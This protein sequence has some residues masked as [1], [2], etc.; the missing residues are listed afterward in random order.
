MTLGSSSSERAIATVWR[1][2]PDSEA[3]T[4][5][6]LGMRADNS[7]SSVQARISIAT[8]SSRSGIELPAEEKVGDDIEVFAQR[9]VL[10]HRGD[11][12]VDR[13]ARVG[14]WTSAPS[15]EIVPESAGARRPGS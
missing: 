13:G 10:E 4:S 2:P 8:S 9:Q 12:Q 5:R 7:L 1:W 6:T 11:A 14:I 3:T 15:K